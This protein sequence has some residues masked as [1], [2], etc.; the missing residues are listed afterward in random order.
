MATATFTKFNCFAEDVGKK[1]HNLASDTFK[2][3]LTN[4]APVAA[5]SKVLTD[6]TE[7]TAANGYAAGGNAVPNTAYA[8]ASGTGTFS[9]DAVTFTGSGGT[10]GPFRYAV[11]YNSTAT[12]K[13]LVGF[14]DYG[15]SGSFDTLVV[16]ENSQSTGGTILTI[17]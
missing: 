14:W 9:G 10:I 6:I 12:G 7:I 5:T 3:C 15:S 4:T 13:N 2:I 11:I 17:A 8:Q 16:N 1:V